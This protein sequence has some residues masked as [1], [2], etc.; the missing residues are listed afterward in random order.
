MQPNR[1]VKNRSY[2]WIAIRQVA[3]LTNWSANIVALLANL[4]FC[5]AQA[6]GARAEKA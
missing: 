6:S 2:L 1:F 3:E 4:G 5:V